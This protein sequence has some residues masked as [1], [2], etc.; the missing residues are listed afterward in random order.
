MLEAARNQGKYW[1]TLEAVLASQ[2]RWVI[3]H[4]AQVE[5]V[6]P[7]IR[8]VGLDL[9]RLRTEMNAPEIGRRIEQDL[10]DAQ[11]LGVT[12]TPEFFV[13]GRPMPRFGLEELQGLVR[14]ELRKSYP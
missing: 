3:N 2:D 14:E 1:E 11:A 7:A 8:S 12:K 13:N 6:W 10:A 9:D 4:V 5:G